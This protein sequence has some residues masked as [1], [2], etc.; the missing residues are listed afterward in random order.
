MVSG[1]G[2]SL[3]LFVLR[4]R[5]ERARDGLDF[6]EEME[7]LRPKW[8]SFWV[9]YVVKTVGWLAPTPCLAPRGSR[10]ANL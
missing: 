3:R 5:S 2:L 4:E 7:L 6:D 1:S 10:G 9:D 8:R